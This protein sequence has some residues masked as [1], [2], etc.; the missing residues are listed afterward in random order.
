MEISKKVKK[1]GNSAV[2]VLTSEDLEIL[3]VKV[4]D[5]LRCSN[6]R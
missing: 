2:V 4:G 1:W 5:V 6:D 3:G